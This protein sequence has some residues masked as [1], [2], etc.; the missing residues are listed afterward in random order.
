L[1]TA[2]LPRLAV[3]SSL[4]SGSKDHAVDRLAGLHQRDRHAPV[5]DAVQVVAGAVERVD[6][7][8]VAAGA[9]VALLRAAFLAEHAVFGIGTAQFLD[10]LRLGQ[11]V[12]LAG[13]VHPPLFHHV[14]RVQ[15]VHVAQQD[16]AAGA[17]R[18]DH[19]VDGGLLHD[20]GPRIRRR[21]GRGERAAP[22]RWPGAGV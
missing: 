6:D 15:L 2:P 19:D 1:S 18:L 17:G 8:G 21:D 12:D 3:N 5:R 11:A 20:D 13:V 14:Q 22:A 10:D 9:T 7:P 16:V 4:R